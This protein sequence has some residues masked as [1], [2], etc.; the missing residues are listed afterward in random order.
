[1]LLFAF[2]REIAYETNFS[3][4]LEFFAKFAKLNPHE[5]FFFF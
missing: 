1:M 4:F 2:R 5:I 3:D